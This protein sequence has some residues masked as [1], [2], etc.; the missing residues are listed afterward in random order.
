MTTFKKAL[1][2]EPPFFGRLHRTL[3]LNVVVFAGSEAFLI[4]RDPV[5][6]G[7]QAFDGPH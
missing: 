7:S 1:V 3:L 5:F 2:A 6:N 4:E